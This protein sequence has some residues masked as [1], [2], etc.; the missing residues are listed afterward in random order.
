[1][2]RAEIKIG[3]QSKG[4]DPDGNDLLFDKAREGEK[5]RGMGDLGVR[6]ADA[7]SYGRIVL[8]VVF[9][10]SATPAQRMLM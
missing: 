7:I 3:L 4:R 6:V 10:P 5:N 8:R 2:Q 1:M 9:H